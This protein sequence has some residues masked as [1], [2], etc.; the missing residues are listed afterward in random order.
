MPHA[1]KKQARVAVPTYH[2]FRLSQLMT[3]V[4]K[5]QTVFPGINSAHG[6]DYHYPASQSLELILEGGLVLNWIKMGNI[7]NKQ[8]N[9]EKP[10]PTQETTLSD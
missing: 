7:H 4:E 8:S 6:T 3:T 10:K 1:P 2:T 9:K 5:K